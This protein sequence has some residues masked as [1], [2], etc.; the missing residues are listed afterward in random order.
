MIVYLV[1]HGETVMNKKGVTQGHKDSPI[2]SRGMESAENHGK[3]L[4]KENIE[5]V[6]S[7]DLGRCVQTAEIINNY[8]KKELIKT[9][10][11]RE[12]DFGLLNGQPDKRVVRELDLSNPDEIAPNGESFNQMKNRVLEFIKSLADKDF[13]KVLLITHEGPVRAILSEYYGVEF[14]SKKGDSSSEMVYRME[15]KDGK[16]ESFECVT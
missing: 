2:T 12:R 8:I 4:S 5:I 11:L 14:N 6:F 7:S 9:P 1:R 10:E 13:N 3:L 15:V 16:I